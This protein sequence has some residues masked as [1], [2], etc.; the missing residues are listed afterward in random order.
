[1]PFHIKSVGAL[2]TG[3]IYYKGGQNWTQTY[4]DRK[5]YSS[6]SD[7]TNAKDATI[8]RSIGGRTYNYRPDIF[9]NA[10]VVSE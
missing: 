9:K 7:A 10:S 4:A 5:Q 6:S 2:G 1:M 3:D 8:T